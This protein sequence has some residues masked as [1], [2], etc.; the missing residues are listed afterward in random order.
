[1][2]RSADGTE[3]GRNEFTVVPLGQDF[4]DMSPPKKELMKLVLEHNIAQ[5]GNVPL[6]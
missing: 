4:R 1:M 5:G 3:L 2:G 6:R